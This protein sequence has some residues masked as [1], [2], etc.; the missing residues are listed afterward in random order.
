MTID[1]KGLEKSTVRLG[2][3]SELKDRSH[4]L[5]YRNY[6]V[7]S[8]ELNAAKLSFKE[9]EFQIPHRISPSGDSVMVV[10][11]GNHYK[12]IREQYG[13]LLALFVLARQYQN[14]TLHCKYCKRTVPDQCQIAGFVNFLMS[15]ASC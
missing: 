11:I 12:R 15:L 6:F 3:C 14:G 13:N 4:M 2:S 10:K 5:E 8:G 1:L 9:I 7:P